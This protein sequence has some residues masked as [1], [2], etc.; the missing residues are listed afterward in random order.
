MFVRPLYIYIFF[1]F[2]VV[3]F[4][5]LLFFFLLKNTDSGVISILV[6]AR[7]LDTSQIELEF[8]K[9]ILNSNDI[10]LLIF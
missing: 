4:V 8:L 2:V 3:V 9:S 7:Y 5:F 6:P 10:T 1:F